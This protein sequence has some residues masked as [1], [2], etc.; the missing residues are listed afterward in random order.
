[1]RGVDGLE[2]DEEEIPENLLH[3]AQ[4]VIKQNQLHRTRPVL[5]F[6]VHVHCLAFLPGQR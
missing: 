6:M 1:M 3:L 2:S 4:S 5:C